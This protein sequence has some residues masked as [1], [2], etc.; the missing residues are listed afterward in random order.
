MESEERPID[1]VRFAL[2][3]YLNDPPDTE[4]QRGY[5]AALV[6]IYREAFHQNNDLANECDQI[7]R[8]SQT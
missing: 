1:Y 5:L 6:A 4:F 3:A 7:L 8:D 2:E